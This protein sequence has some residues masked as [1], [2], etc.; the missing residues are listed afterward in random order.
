M[1]KNATDR[2]AN[3]GGRRREHR[4]SGRVRRQNGKLLILLSD[5][6]D[7]QHSHDHDADAAQAQVQTGLL[8]RRSTRRADAPTGAPR[9]GFIIQTAPGL[10]A[11]RRS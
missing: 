9:T 7:E 8:D 2:N 10:G 11:R 6:D 5:A 3:A 4:R 1:K